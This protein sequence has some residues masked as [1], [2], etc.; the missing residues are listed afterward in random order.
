MDQAVTGDTAAPLVMTRTDLVA[1]GHCSRDE[2]PG[3]EWR[4]GGSA[5]YAAATSARLGARTAL[6]TRVGP[7]ERAALERSCAEL[8]IELR[9][10]PSNVTT[11]FA[12][13]WDSSGRR[14][15]RLRARAK[16]LRADDVPADLRAPR[17]GLLGSIA[18]ELAPD[19]FAAFEGSLRVLA[20]QGQL[21]AWDADGTVRPGEWDGAAEALPGVG[22]VV[23][24][25]EDVA[26]DP[27]LPERWSLLVPVALTLAER[28]A[29]LLA[30]GKVVAE[31]AACR[32]ERVVDPTGAGDAFAAGLA[33]ALAE[34]RMLE[35]AGR[36]ANAVASFAV[37]GVGTS[38]LGDRQRVEA[39]LAG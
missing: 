23:L 35:D 5:L 19:L 30:G 38:A 16:G 33:I 4:L 17:A 24:S 21:R 31:I 1:I 9:A 32:V 20:A 6:V 25:D 26:G 14:I 34:G 15:L 36:F 37:E 39:R 28:G 18:H 8:G 27:A 13:R 11:T 2:F 10:L 22:A 29:R 7:A 3:G 12:F